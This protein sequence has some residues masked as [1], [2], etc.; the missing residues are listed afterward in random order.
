VKALA[1]A[2]AVAAVAALLALALAAW[3]LHLRLVELRTTT[4]YLN[5]LLPIIGG[6]ATNVEKTLREEREASKEQLSQSSAVLKNVNAAVTQATGDLAEFRELLAGIERTNRTLDGAIAEQSG[7]A[8]ATEKEAQTALR[9][10][11][12]ALTRADAV[13]ASMDRLA[14]NPDAPEALKRLDA[15]IAEAN[16]VLAHVDGAAAS[17]ERDMLL[18]EAR[19][20]EA[21]KPASLA[22]TIFMRAVGIAGPAAQIATAAK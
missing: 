3:D 16:S 22:K 4:T 8:T 18:I 1:A 2:R 9:D 14:N 19:L 11:A 20:R 13:L 6:A 15:A 12:A 7:Q 5:Q 17:G 10:L 21:L